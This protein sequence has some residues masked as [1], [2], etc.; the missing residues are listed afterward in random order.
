[1]E[2]Y[3]RLEMGSCC[4]IRHTSWQVWQ[5]QNKTSKQTKI[6]KWKGENEK[7]KKS[8]GCLADV[9]SEFCDLTE[10]FLVRQTFLQI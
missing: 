7:K 1:M 6:N 10:V 8:F 5:I 3:Q 4:L 9:L 2:T